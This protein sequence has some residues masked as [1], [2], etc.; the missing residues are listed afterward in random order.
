MKPNHDDDEPGI[1]GCPRP[2]LPT[3]TDLIPQIRH[4][5]ILMMQGH[6]YDN[7]LGAL[8]RGDG[9]VLLGGEIQ[10]K[11]ANYRLDGATVPVHSLDKTP[12][13]KDV[14]L[15]DSLKSAHVQWNDGKGDGFV[16][17]L[18]AAYPWQS[19]AD[20]PMGYWTKATL[21]FYHSLAMTFPLA[22][23]W[24]SSFL[25]P[26]MPNR[27][28]LISGTAHGLVDDSPSI[29]IGYPKSGTI[30]DLLA[31]NK[32]PWTNYICKN[33]VSVMLPRF[34]DP[35]GVVA[36]LASGILSALIPLDVTSTS[37]GTL[38]CSAEVYRLGLLRA[39]RHVRSIE[40]FFA[41]AAAGSLPAVSVVDPDWE[42]GS[43][44]P[45]QDVRIGEAFAEKVIRSVMQGK[46]WPH[47]LLIWLYDNHGGFYDHVAP[48]PASAVAPDNVL[49]RSLFDRGELL[50][51][52]PFGRLMRDLNSAPRTYDQLG[53]R[54]PAVVVSPYAKRGY[55]SSTVYDH[56]SVLKLIEQ[57]WNLPPLTRRDAAAI[58]PLDMLDFE[59]P[60]AFLTP[61]TLS[62]SSRV[63][64]RPRAPL[65][66]AR[67][68]FKIESGR[69]LLKALILIGLT[70]LTGFL[71]FNGSSLALQ[72]AV[73]LASV[74]LTLQGVLKSGF[75]KNWLFWKPPKYRGRIAIYNAAY[76]LIVMITVFALI[77]AYGF[78]H[79]PFRVKPV[80][81]HGKL[82]W[83]YTTT[84]AWNFID[85]LP[86][87]KI[88]STFHWDQPL[89]FSD[90][91]SETFLILFRL[92]VLAPV[93]SLIVQGVK[94]ASEKG[95]RVK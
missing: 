77:S 80:E 93:V 95:G 16:R 38:R 87:V 27:R 71:V 33:P 55:I 5:V 11:E 43:E 56:T 51:W 17:S 62:S 59:S 36:P 91:F 63:W 73:V 49:G 31:S 19:A 3:G 78:M 70:W 72:L 15:A 81:A 2:D 48:P 74:Y 18:Q 37:H 67:K 1:T 21:P 50:S 44:G 79:G 7:Y 26:V 25:G 58:S 60:P 65:V 46:G 39:I 4:I 35:W 82:L 29:S 45:G 30:F 24:F 85:A 69:D 47:T 14:F 22:D 86:G 94:S 90:L 76:A 8:G 68:A 28:F 9:L 40:D 52:L 13:L 34:L 61:P 64:K 42:E 6:S 57:K 89:D 23:R 20:V 84:Y 83:E 92:L 32:I 54:I 75:Y 53:F 12:Q 88:T 41:D 66:D 10:S